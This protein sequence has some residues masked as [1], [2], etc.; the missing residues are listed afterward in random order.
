MTKKTK[1]ILACDM[2][3]NEV[4]VG[5]KV[6]YD[7]S[8]IAYEVVELY[9]SQDGVRVGIEDPEARGLIWA[10]Q[11]HIELIIEENPDTQKRLKK[12][13]EESIQ[14]IYVKLDE[15][16][17]NLNYEMKDLPV[18]LPPYIN[19]LQTCKNICENL[20][21]DL[22]SRAKHAGRFVQ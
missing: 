5:D 1:D 8:V 14:E 7:N 22:R 19:L 18:L 6:W 2:D 11:D 17:C 15:L 9:E 4:R 12:V 16:T 10:E 13:T 21:H 3:D 20:H